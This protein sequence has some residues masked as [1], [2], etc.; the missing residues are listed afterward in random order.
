MQK[1]YRIK[2]T[3]EIDAIF[4]KKIRVNGKYFNIFYQLSNN[5]SFR[6]A[7]SIGKKYGN[8]VKRNLMKRRIREIIRSIKDQIK[9]YDFIIVVKPNSE[10]LN[11]ETINQELFKLLIKAKILEEVK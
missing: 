5:E 1:K 2:K 3:S 8:A 10:E 9:S 7:I 6:F 11:F 4:N